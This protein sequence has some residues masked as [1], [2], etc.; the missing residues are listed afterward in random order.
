MQITKFP[1]HSLLQVHPEMALMPVLSEMQE[2]FVPTVAFTWQMENGMPELVF[3]WDTKKDYNSKLSRIWYNNIVVKSLA[4]IMPP[5]SVNYCKALKFVEE[6]YLNNKV[7]VFPQKIIE[8]IGKISSCFKVNYR[9]AHALVFNPEVTPKERNAASFK[10]VDAFILD[11]HPTQKKL[12]ETTRQ[13]IWNTS[14]AK[15]RNPVEGFSNEELELIKDLVWVSAGPEEVPLQMEQ[16]AHDLCE[17]IASDEETLS[18]MSFAHQKLIEIHPYAEYNGRIARIFMA[19]LGMW[20]GKMPLLIDDASEYNKAAR[21]LD[22]A[23]FKL[24]LQQLETKQ[25]QLDPFI[26]DSL[27]FYFTNIS[28][29]K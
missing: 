23:R 14:F 5:E 16:F 21:S 6:N 19:L 8:I 17:K 22:P 2:L 7:E 25:L 18:L 15:V 29:S 20:N 4:P 11:K 9:V 13:K 27:R 26:E 12:W 1:G 28:E 24:Y 10:K 3:F